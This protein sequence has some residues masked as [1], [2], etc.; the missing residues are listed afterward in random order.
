MNADEAMT[1][2]RDNRLSIKETFKLWRMLDSRVRLIPS[3]V[4]LDM[5]MREP[6]LFEPDLPDSQGYIYFPWHEG[7][8]Q[9]RKKR[10]ANTLGLRPK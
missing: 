4:V 1:L 5:R 10:G 2:I 7:Y 6:E 3:D 9:L 8:D